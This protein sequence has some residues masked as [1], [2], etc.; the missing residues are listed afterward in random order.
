M[1]RENVLYL[2]GEAVQSF[3]RRQHDGVGKIK[4]RKELRSAYAKFLQS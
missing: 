1:S 3:V 4:Y 2:I